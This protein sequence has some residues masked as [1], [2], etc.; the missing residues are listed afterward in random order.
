MNFNF[1]RDAA[2]LVSISIELPTTPRDDDR[3]SFN[4]PP[5]GAYVFF[6]Y[7]SI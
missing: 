1:T 5:G 2:V 6:E 7:I 3:S 4:D